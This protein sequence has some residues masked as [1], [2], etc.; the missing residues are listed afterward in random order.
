[1]AEV[2]ITPRISCDNCGFTEDKKFDQGYS[3]DWHRP[4]SW[5]GC[6]IESYSTDSYGSKER[7]DFTD[8]C[9]KCAKALIDAAGEALRLARGEGSDG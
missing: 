3:K 4:K 8:L 1:M 7:M 6:K 9:P 2:K 5:G